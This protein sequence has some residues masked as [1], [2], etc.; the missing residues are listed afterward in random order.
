MNSAQ[1]LKAIIKREFSSYFH[2]AIAYVFL[3]VFLVFSTFLTFRFGGWFSLNKADLVPFFSFHPYLYL[4]FIPALAM[5]AWAEEEREG[6]VE[7]LLTFPISAWQAVLAKFLASWLFLATALFLTFPMVFTV[8]SLGD[9]DPGMII[10]GYIASLLLGGVFLSLSTLASVL[11]PNQV[12]SYIVSFILLLFMSGVGLRKIS[13]IFPDWLSDDLLVT[14]ELFSTSP[15]FEAFQRGVLDARDVLY[16]L[17]IILFGLLS[18]TAVLRC[19]KAAHKHNK[20]ITFAGLAVLSVILLLVNVLANKLTFRIDLT[21]DRLYTLSESTDKVL[22]KL[23]APVTVRFYFSKSHVDTDLE[24]KAFALRVEDLIKEFVY[25]SDENLSYEIIDPV[26]GS[27]EEGR[28]I[29]DGMKAFNFDKDRPAYFGLS[30]QYLDKNLNLPELTKL[31]ESNL[32]FQMTRLFNE[33]LQ[34]EKPVLAIM[35]PLSVYGQDADVSKQRYQEVPA[36]RFIQEMS[37]DYTVYQI[38][39]ELQ[40]I[41]PKVQV[42]ILL[43]P[44]NLPLST[45]YALDQYVMQG[46]RVIAFLDPYYVLNSQRIQQ[47]EQPVAYQSSLTGLSEAWGVRLDLKSLLYDEANEI[48]IQ[49]ER[50]PFMLNFSEE[51]FDKSQEFLKTLK[52][53]KMSYPGVIQYQATK[54]L[55]VTPVV[56]SS[57][58]AQIIELKGGLQPKELRKTY[59]ADGKEHAVAVRIQGDVETAFKNDVPKGFEDRHLT[60]STKPMDVV[61]VADADMMHNSFSFTKEQDFKK[62]EQVT[63]NS[64][65]IDFLMNLIEE[66][67]SDGDLIA[68]RSRVKQ[69]RALTGFEDKKVALEAVYGSQRSELYKELNAAKKERDELK[70]KQIKQFLLNREEKSRLETL[71]TQISDLELELR[72]VDRELAKEVE[73]YQTSVALR[74]ILIIPFIIILFGIFSSLRQ[75]R[76]VARR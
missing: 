52:R 43:H 76:K 1:A 51:N 72:K 21:Q 38:P 6:T 19:R 9:P 62:G 3:V 25:S 34:E 18:T 10:S 37:K 36:W 32:E 39:H 54:G 11:T 71:A 7:L 17:S 55:T 29:L 24:K 60:K 30:I 64:N 50:R 23:K 66:M 74:N 33:A 27:D 48:T 31:S 59:K 13:E 5:R 35:T 49:N 68:L 20:S 73:S 44:E 58:T 63:R 57:K 53:L 67:S 4:F 2:S 45:L 26:N 56:K 75:K 70:Q 40:F 28:A 14:L 65:N 15:H 69:N 12:I 41:D 8:F 46:G 42:L 47:G 22:K 61:L 16:N